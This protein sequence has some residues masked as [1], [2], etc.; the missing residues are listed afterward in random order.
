[1]KLYITY[2]FFTFLRFFQ[3]P[4]N[5][6]VYVFFE[7]L[8]TFSGTLTQVYISAPVASASMSTYSALH[9]LRWTHWRLDEKQQTE[10]ECRQD[11]AG[12]AR[13]RSATCQADHHRAPT[14]LCPHHAVVCSASS[15]SA[16]TSTASWPWSTTSPHYAG[17]AY[18]KFNY[19]SQLRMVRSSLTSDTTKTLVHA[20]VSSRLDYCKGLLYGISYGLLMKL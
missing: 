6:T 11:T 8:N 13:D 9:L 17:R 7:M 1:V 4:K 10:N 2:F 19:A 14:A 16:S 15:T 20:F 18:F 5:M 12:V 3:N